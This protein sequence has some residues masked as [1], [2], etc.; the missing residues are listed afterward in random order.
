M[1]QRYNDNDYASVFVRYKF[2]L[3]T[4]KQLPTTFSFFLFSR[5]PLSY[6]LT[7]SHPSTSSGYST[8]PQRGLNGRKVDYPRGRLLGGCSSINGMLS[9]RGARRDYEW[10]EAVGGEEASTA[11]QEPK[12]RATSLPLAL[13]LFCKTCF[14]LRVPFGYLGHQRKR[15]SQ[16][17]QHRQRELH[18]RLFSPSTTYL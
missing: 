7:M 10:G 15:R 18:S 16:D 12:G 3:L 4:C 14:L 17:Q 1:W 13:L 5:V 6:L 2:G 11:F 9:L 8:V